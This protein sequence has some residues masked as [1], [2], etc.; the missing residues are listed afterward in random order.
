[1]SSKLHNMFRRN[2]TL[3]RVRRRLHDEPANYW[4]LRLQ[5]NYPGF[6]Q[7][8]LCRAHHLSDGPIRFKYQRLHFMPIVLHS[9]FADLRLVL[10]LPKQPGGEVAGKHMRMRQ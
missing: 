10:N 4:I 6:R 2:R 8:R 7:W 9:V 3:H 5:S 1:M